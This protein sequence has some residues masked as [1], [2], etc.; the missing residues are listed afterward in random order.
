MDGFKGSMG[1]VT[2]IDPSIYN[3]SYLFQCIVKLQITGALSKFKINVVDTV[4]NVC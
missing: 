1:H 4:A 3:S 2:I